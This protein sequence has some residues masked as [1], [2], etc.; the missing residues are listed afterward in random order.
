MS[1]EAFA[2]IINA[3]APVILFGVAGFV[4]GGVFI[5]ATVPFLFIVRLGFPKI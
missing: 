4:V 2:E 1:L 5:A 3:F